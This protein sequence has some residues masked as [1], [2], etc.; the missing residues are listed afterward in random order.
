VTRPENSGGFYV[1]CACLFLKNHPL[2]HF[3]P[4]DLIARNSS[5]STHS[6]QQA[7][8]TTAAH[9]LPPTN[10]ADTHITRY[11]RQPRYPRSPP[12]FFFATEGLI[13][14]ASTVL[15][16]GYTLIV[17]LT[18]AEVPAAVVFEVVCLLFCRLP[19]FSETQNPSLCVRPSAP[20]TV[21]TSYFFPNIHND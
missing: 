12:F 4:H 18:A 1:C 21:V 11:T 15:A 10:C 7:R 14:L 3:F 8:S 19:P 17:V 20:Q 9:R 13:H 2:C 16:S 6:F 5:S